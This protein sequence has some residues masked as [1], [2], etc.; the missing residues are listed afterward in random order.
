MNGK[1][2]RKLRNLVYGEDF[3]PRYRQYYRHK[4]KNFVIADEKRR[5]YQDSKEDL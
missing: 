3:S 2:A 5:E 1:K 4:K